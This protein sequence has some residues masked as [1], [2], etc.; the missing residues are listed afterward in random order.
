MRALT[1]AIL[2]LVVTPFAGSGNA[3]A[4]DRH[5]IVVSDRGEIMVS[6]DQSAP[7]GEAYHGYYFE[8]HEYREQQNYAQIANWVKHQL[9]IVDS[10]GVSSRVRD[11]FR[12]IP[13]IVDEAA[14]SNGKQEGS[15]QLS[16]ICYGPATS[17]QLL[18]R[19]HTD[20]VWDPEKRDWTNLDPV[21]LAVDTHRGVVLV[22]PPVTSSERPVLLHEMLH[23]Y[24]ANMMPN[25]ANNPSILFYYDHAKSAQLYP[26]DAYLMTNEKEF[27]AVTAS[28]FLCGKDGDFTRSNIKEKQPDYYKF[29][30]WLFGFDPDHLQKSTPVASAN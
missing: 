9:D 12:T 3:K 24:H 18:G 7:K 5:R 4:D 13:I 20:T 8:L 22:R 23:A 16:L 10:V 19:L 11:F 30:V 2:A 17:E 25:G 1:L 28:V 27:F 15:P 26:V 29:L 14:C 6:E 21:A